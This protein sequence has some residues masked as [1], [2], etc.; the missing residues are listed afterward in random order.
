[1]EGYSL[2]VNFIRQTKQYQM[3]CPEYK[4]YADLRAAGNSMYDAWIVAFQGKGLSWPKAELTKEMNKLEA[5]DSVQTRI[6]ELQGRNAP[7]TEEITAEELTKETSKE[8][9][10]RKLVAAEK[11]AKKGSPDWLKIVSLIADY[12][13]IKQDEIDTESNTV[14]FHLP[15]QYPNRCE[16]C[17]IF[18][19]GRATAQKKKK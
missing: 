11:K 5:L 4:I 7:K 6:A 1:M 19:N 15:V 3:A 18:Q 17:L 8:S 12:N 9:I 10:L 14:H 2:S 13:K 16:E